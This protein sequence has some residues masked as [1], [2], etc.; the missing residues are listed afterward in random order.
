MIGSRKA[1][2][3]DS[4]G[5][6]Q[7]VAAIRERGPLVHNVTNVVVMDITANALL[8]LGASPVMAH[9]RQEVGDMA[10]LADSV[11]LNMGTLDDGWIASMLAALESARKHG[12]P[13][14]FDPVGAGA[15]AYRSETA[16]VLLKAGGVTVVRGNASEI[17]SLAGATG[18]TK[19]VDS[20]DESVQVAEVATTLLEHCQVVVISGQKDVVVGRDARCVLGNGCAMMTRITG[21]GC[22]ATALVGA[23]LAVRTDPFVA[24]AHAMAVM[25]IAGE[26][27][28]EQSAG[29]GSLRVHFVDA[30][31]SLDESTLAACLRV[32]S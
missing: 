19:G 20:L 26:I 15:T 5:V 3:I 29:P 4:R 1:R 16:R 27:T 6:W 30:L 12:K 17:A 7:D 23:F 18:R 2:M 21:M 9:A 25:G 13:V 8:A 11:V 10:A 28:R 31:Y 24:A 22:T 14:V 32:A